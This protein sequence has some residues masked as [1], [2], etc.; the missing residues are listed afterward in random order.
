MYIDSKLDWSPADRNAINR[1]AQISAFY[2][3]P[4]KSRP[5]DMVAVGITK[6]MY[7]ADLRNRYAAYHIDSER[8]TTAYTAS[9]AARLVRGAYLISGLTYTTHPVFTPH[10]SDALLLQES[11]TFTF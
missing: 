8:D 3:G 5:F 2:V 9:Y 7:S 10:H 11:L 4:F 6:S 1:A